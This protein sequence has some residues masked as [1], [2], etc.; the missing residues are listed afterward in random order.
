MVHVSDEGAGYD[1]KRCDCGGTMVVNQKYLVCGNCGEHEKIQDN[2]CTFCWNQQL[3]E[4]REGEYYN[5]PIKC[6]ECGN[7][8]EGNK[9]FYK[10]HIK[11]LDKN[12]LY[13]DLKTERCTECGTILGPVNYSNYRTCPHCENIEKVAH[14]SYYNK[15]NIECMDA[16]ASAIIGLE[17]VEAFY[18]GNVIKYMWRWKEKNGAEDLEKAKFYIDLLL[19]LKEE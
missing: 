11:E 2:I 7:G 5:L 1:M 18:T 17:P 8:N 13:P 10:T 15:G 19:K 16:I 12:S 14:P 6:K 4:T 9:D 3:Y